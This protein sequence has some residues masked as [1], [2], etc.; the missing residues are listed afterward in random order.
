LCGLLAL[1]GHGLALL[2]LILTR[3][4]CQAS[5][6]SDPCEVDQRF[7][8]LDWFSDTC[9]RVSG[10][11]CLSSGRKLQDVPQDR[12]NVRRC[13]WSL[14]DPD[15][16]HHGVLS[17][18]GVVVAGGVLHLLFVQLPPRLVQLLAVLDSPQLLF[19]VAALKDAG[20]WWRPDT[21]TRWPWSP[22]AWVEPGSP[23]APDLVLDLRG[24][25]PCMHSLRDDG[26]AMRIPTR[27]VRQGEDLI[28]AL[29][30]MIHGRA[31]ALA[32]PNPYHLRT[33]HDP[34]LSQI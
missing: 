18:L 11:L 25:K 7:R 13:C 2:L 20:R 30:P 1:P 22:T 34:K 6:L 14:G 28:E 4:R 32:I 17:R 19:R 16:C 33:T 9:P 21:S 26:F 8:H 27:A 24:V 12:Q 3:G 23:R 29:L 31:R 15:A 10:Q 5:L